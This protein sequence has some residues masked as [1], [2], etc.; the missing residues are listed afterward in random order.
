M[1]LSE[2]SSVRCLCVHAHFY[3][4]PRE[5]PWLDYVALDPSAYPSHDWNERVYNEC[6]KPNQA[7]RLI[8]REGKITY[9]TNNYK[10]LSFNVGPTLH[11][12][13]AQKDQDLASSI[14]EADRSSAIEQG[15]GGAI[16]QAYN[17]MIMPLASHR[18]KKTQI[19]WGVRDFE[20]RFGRKPRGMWL[21][22]TAVDLES[23]EIMADN[24]IE[25]TILA[26]HQCVAVKNPSGD[27]LP[28]NGGSDLDV[29][30]PYVQMLPSGKRI[31]IVFY[32]GS[33]AHDIA[34]GG[35]LNSGDLFAQKLRRLVA[36]KQEP[37][38]VT[39]ATD[40]ETYGHHHRYG[41]M[42]LARAFQMINDFSSNSITTNIAAFLDKFPATWECRVQENTS[43]SCAHGIERWRSDCGC[44]TG[45]GFG[46]N[47]QWRTPLRAALDGLRDR[48]D[49]IYEKR[50][51]KISDSPWELRDE[52]IELYLSNGC[53][54]DEN[55]PLEE[56]RSFLKRRYG[57]LSETA[58]VEL[59]SLLEVQR[60]RL[61][62]YT[63]C[64][65]FF[66]DI[67]GIETRQILAYAIR[68]SELVE[69]V[70]GIDMMDDFLKQLELAKGNT[71]EG[72]DGRM[73]VERFVFPQ[74]VSLEAAAAISSLLDKEGS[75]HSFKVTSET[76]KYPSGDLCLKASRMSVVDTGT[77]AAWKGN[78]IVFSAGGLDDVCRL[79]VRNNPTDSDIR[80]FFY[81]SDILRISRYLEETYELGP[82]N[83][84]DLPEDSKLHIADVIVEKAES[85][86]LDAAKEILETNQRLMV[87]LQLLKV[88]SPAIFSAAANLVFREKINELSETEPSVLNLLKQ[89]SSLI[90]LLSEAK[91]LGVISDL[92]FLAPRI[93]KEMNVVVGDNFLVQD[94]GVY[95]KIIY[96][97]QKA[98]ELGIQLDLYDLQNQVWRVLE[99]RSA[100]PSRVILN[101]AAELNFAVP[102]AD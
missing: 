92:S 22:E 68:A 26:P 55:D 1:L 90:L 63:S 3:Q 39:I 62:M 87:Q 24:G 2:V 23:L 48:I 12:W 71:R 7:A 21:P 81:A 53:N 70:C 79:S 69:R 94:E 14:L 25:F 77:G 59:L 102:G 52:A 28:T 96:F 95:D 97:L 9:I 27:W 16:A 86:Q 8:D 78:A 73:V 74:R 64:G 75:Y 40:G 56:K 13:I 82:W 36:D 29:S 43:W 6:Y 98:K 100:S 72:A 31:T 44:H 30:R 66:N 11:R 57:S 50:V 51:N 93:E 38:L 17:H 42:A 84:T 80:K 45:G 47:Q 60:M 46:W 58:Q 101:L 34:F 99:S 18:D 76:K 37:C 5:N 88:A 91:S 19:C 67:A 10:H 54:G 33:V 85:Q 49:E 65:W 35:L 32:Q 20:F 83:F 61:F 4:P 15:M 89:G 41:E